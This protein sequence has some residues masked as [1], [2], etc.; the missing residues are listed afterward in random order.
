M[1]QTQQSDQLGETARI[2][3]VDDEPEILTLVSRVLRESDY[4]VD[5]ALSG[6]LGLELALTGEYALIVLD[7]VLP[8]VDGLTALKAIMAARP[9]QAVLVL[10]ALC[11]VESKVRCLEH[12]AADYLT[13]PFALDELL[14]RVRA[15]LRGAAMPAG[16]RFL[17][18][19]PITLD[20]HRHVADAGDGEVALSSRE[21]ELLRHLMQRLG[22]VCTREQLLA[23]VWNTPFDPHTNVVD[24]YIRRL[25]GKLGVDAIET[26]RNVG[27]A[28][29]ES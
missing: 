12:G 11:D 2:L 3:V 7:L 28:L 25:R 20:L 10:S 16:D 4:Q 8:D 24:V 23:D 17:R 13:K 29:R 26:L 22:S 18:A 14:A 27:Y 21:Y 15:R 19:G 9:E 6:S 5:C 1:E